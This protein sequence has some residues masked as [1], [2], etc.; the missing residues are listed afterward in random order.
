MLIAGNDQV[1][2]KIMYKNFSA[3][4]F[5]HASL[6]SRNMK[7]KMNSAV[8]TLRVV[9]TPMAHILECLESNTDYFKRLASLEKSK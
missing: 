6:R 1:T 5:I 2:H 7:N 8:E 3:V 9:P 4:S